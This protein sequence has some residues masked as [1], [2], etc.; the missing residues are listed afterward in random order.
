MGIAWGHERR[1]EETNWVGVVQIR[2]ACEFRFLSKSGGVRSGSK[3]LLLVL[4]ISTPDDVLGP[5][6]ACERTKYVRR[7]I[8][9]GGVTP[10]YVQ[11]RCRREV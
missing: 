9:S 5:L 7:S 6:D 4:I 1:E 2:K 3:L 10:I 11:G 8:Y